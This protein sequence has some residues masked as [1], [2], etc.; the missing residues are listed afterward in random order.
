MKTAS[1]TTSLIACAV[2]VGAFAIGFATGPAFADKALTKD[3][4]FAFEFAFEQS[5]LTSAPAAEKLLTRLEQGVR[6]HCGDR[7]GLGT[8]KQA[9]VDRCIDTTMRESVAKFGSSMVAQA[10]QSQ[11]GG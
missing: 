10:Y 8:E 7:N 1:S 5:E 6:K 3:K 4:P 11:A 2:I 9:N